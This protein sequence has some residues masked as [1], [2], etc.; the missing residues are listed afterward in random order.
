A[1]ARQKQL[2][3]EPATEV[4]AF[5][6]VFARDSW[7]GFLQLRIRSLEAQGQPDPDEITSFYARAGDLDRA[8]AWLEKSYAG[9]SARLTNL[10]V[11]GRYDHLR[12][13]P[14]FADMLRRVGL[15]S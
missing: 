14:R 1:Y 6:D 12:T 11:D 2:D 4:D 13:D 7:Q 5:K 10:N 3:G 15:G 8:F 9:R